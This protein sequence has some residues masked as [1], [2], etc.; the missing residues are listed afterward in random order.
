MLREKNKR[1]Q[2]LLTVSQHNSPMRVKSNF[3]S[4]MLTEHL[5]VSTSPNKYYLV[6]VLHKLVAC[7]LNLTISKLRYLLARRKAL[8]ALFTKKQSRSDHTSFRNT[9]HSRM[10][11]FSS[12]RTFRYLSGCALEFQMES[13]RVRRQLCT[14]A[15]LHR[16][17]GSS[18]RSLCGLGKTFSVSVSSSLKCSQ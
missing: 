6:L 4:P 7:T 18:A 12:R 3:V 14:Q 5:L 1:D 9:R 2:K 8:M 13:Y 16:K 10:N 15:G 11:I 17:P